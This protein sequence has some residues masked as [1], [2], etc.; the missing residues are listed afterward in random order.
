MERTKFIENQSYFLSASSD[1]EINYFSPSCSSDYANYGNRSCFGLDGNYE[2][3]AKNNNNPINAVTAWILIPGFTDTQS[4]E[5]A[6]LDEIWYR[7][8]EVDWHDCTYTSETSN[9][10]I[11]TCVLDPEYPWD[12]TFD[13]DAGS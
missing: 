8:N 5:D 7:Y 13:V 4:V 3:E 2:F 12:D 9:R 6:P 1:A 11:R 10:K